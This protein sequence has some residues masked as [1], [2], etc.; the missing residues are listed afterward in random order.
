MLGLMAVAFAR[1]ITLAQK[2]NVQ[3]GANKAGLLEAWIYAAL[4]QLSADIAAGSIQERRTAAEREALA[5][6]NTVHTLLSI[7]AL[8][9][10]VIRREFGR[11]AQRLAKLAGGCV[12]ILSVISPL[13]RA[14]AIPVL[15]S[16]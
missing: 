3:S 9:L 11:A 7:L 12:L 13:P 6:L 2:M 1:R 10:S 8:T 5:Y 15:D 16:G 4:V 14:N